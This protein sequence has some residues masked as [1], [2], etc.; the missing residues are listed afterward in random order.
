MGGFAVLVVM[1]L[2]VLART[3]EASKVKAVVNDQSAMWNAGNIDGLYATMT[4]SAQQA[5][6]LATLKSLASRGSGGEVA[7]KNMNVRVQGARAFVT[8]F[9]T[10]GGGL[11]GRI[12]DTD[13]AVYVKTDAGWKFDS[14]E[15]VT[16]ICAAAA[17]G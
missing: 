6:P 11:V 5:C 2:L 17:I 8:G 3:S 9:I 16:R 4:A 7:L 15:Q 12:D 14:M 13:P 1:A 10:V